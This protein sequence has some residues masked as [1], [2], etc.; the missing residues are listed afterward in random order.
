MDTVRSLLSGQLTP[1][2]GAVPREERELDAFIA[3]STRRWGDLVST[4]PEDASPRLL[5]GF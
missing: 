3:A 5:H 2:S 4:T 1:S